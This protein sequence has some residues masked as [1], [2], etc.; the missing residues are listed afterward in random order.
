MGVNKSHNGVNLGCSVD[1]CDGAV[2]VKIHDDAV[3]V[4]C[5]ECGEG[6][7]Y[8]RYIGETVLYGGER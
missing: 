2:E 4:T 3:G 6:D 7:N 1:G 5:T 8:P